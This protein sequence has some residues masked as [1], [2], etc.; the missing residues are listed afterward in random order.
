MNISQILFANN[1]N[2]TYQNFEST[3]FNGKMCCYTLVSMVNN[4][5]S[6]IHQI[7]FDRTFSALHLINSFA[8]SFHFQFAN[9]GKYRKF[10]KT[11]YWMQLNVMHIVL[12]F[13]WVWCILC[14]TMRQYSERERERII[15]NFP[16]NNLFRKYSIANTIMSKYCWMANVVRFVLEMLHRHPCD[17]KSH[18]DMSVLF[19]RAQSSQ[20]GERHA[21]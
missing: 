6:T 11:W 2:S 17:R 13:H 15:W 16:L 1:R 18:D 9:S 8:T 14:A 12:S 5:Q 10:N 21:L 7:S 3:I 19:D 4:V 20:F